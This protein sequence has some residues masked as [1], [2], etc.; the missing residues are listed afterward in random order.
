M[1][2]PKDVKC[3]ED[4]EDLT[5]IKCEKCKWRMS[6]VGYCMGYL[7]IKENGLKESGY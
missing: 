4:R 1:K 2:K 3:F 5:E 6:P 7:W